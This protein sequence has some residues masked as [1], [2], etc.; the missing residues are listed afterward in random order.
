MSKFCASY[1]SL[2]ALPC[3]SNILLPVS[4]SCFFFCSFHLTSR[5]SIILCDLVLVF[6]I[7]LLLAC[8]F[9]I[10][11]QCFVFI[12]FPLTLP[13]LSSITD[14]ITSFLKS[15]LDNSCF[16]TWLAASEL[17]VSSIHCLSFNLVCPNCWPR[18]SIASDQFYSFPF[19]SFLLLIYQVF[20]LNHITPNCIP[21]ASVIRVFWLYI[22]QIQIHPSGG[23]VV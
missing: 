10:F 19:W 1:F 2:F 5:Y 15:L 13:P 20:I 23:S 9:C 22:K 18:L 21:A 16:V 8:S 7:F 4:L 11:L 3:T 17:F 14:F 12:Y 6:H